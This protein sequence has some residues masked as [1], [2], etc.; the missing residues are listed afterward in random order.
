M[1]ARVVSD[2][3]ILL[4]ICRASWNVAKSAGRAQQV[5]PPT[6]VQRKGSQCFQPWQDDFLIFKLNV[7][8]HFKSLHICNA[9][10]CCH[11]KQLLWTVSYRI[12]DDIGNKTTNFASR[13]QNIMLWTCY[14][15]PWCVWMCIATWAILCH[16]Y[17]SSQIIPKPGNCG[18]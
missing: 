3:S 5:F 8:S 14:V 12:A 10:F 7:R 6:G 16:F 2:S 13:K 11:S 4:W 18:L 17:M 1:I 9:L 15:P